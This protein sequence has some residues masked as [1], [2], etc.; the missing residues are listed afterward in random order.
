MKYANMNKE[1]STRDL[2][3]LSVRLR[4]L[5]YSMGTVFCG[6]ACDRA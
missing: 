3:M 1:E 4:H 5:Y 2:R 6:V